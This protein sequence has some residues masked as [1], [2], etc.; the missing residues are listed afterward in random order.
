ME[1]AT[2][3][4]IITCSIKKD[5]TIMQSHQESNQLS[6]FEEEEKKKERKEQRM[7]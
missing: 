6:V 5:Y 4:S 7:L 2:P 3:K 1:L